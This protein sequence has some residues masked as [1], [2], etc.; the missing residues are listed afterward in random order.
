MK[1]RKTFV[2]WKSEERLKYIFPLDFAKH[3]SYLEVQKNSK[4]DIRKKVVCSKSVIK[5]FYGSKVLVSEYIF[6]LV[7]HCEGSR[8]SEICCARDIAEKCFNRLLLLLFL[9]SSYPRCTV[10]K[11]VIK[12]SQISQENTCVGVFSG[13][14]AFNI[15]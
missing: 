12:I 13:V 5:A 10:E 14:R 3:L 11:A 7:Y 8:W 15:I 6:K 2:V 4:V 9:K 1:A